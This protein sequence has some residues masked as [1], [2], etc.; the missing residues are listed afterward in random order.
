MEWHCR[1]KAK[2]N[3]SGAWRDFGLQ[4]ESHEKTKR[5]AKIS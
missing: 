1:C 2:V 3:M 5:G 4:S